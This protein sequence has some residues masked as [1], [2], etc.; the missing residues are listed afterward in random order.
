MAGPQLPQ[1]S[2]LLLLPLLLLLLP[3]ALSFLVLSPTAAPAAQR[4]PLLVAAAAADGA[5]VH[6][7]GEVLPEREPTLK[8]TRWVIGGGVM[9]W[10]GASVGGFGLHSGGL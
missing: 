5:E 10:V 4:R 2:R 9:R 8:V 7:I 1:R 3:C 6:K